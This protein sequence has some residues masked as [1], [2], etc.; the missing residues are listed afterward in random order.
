MKEG[1]RIAS[2]DEFFDAAKKAVLTKTPMSP[3]RWV[4]SEEACRQADAR[5]VQAAKADSPAD[6][7]RGSGKAIN[8]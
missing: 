1:H 3:K 7:Y 4:G 5:K 8:R 2:I 6:E